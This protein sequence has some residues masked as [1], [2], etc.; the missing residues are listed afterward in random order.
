MD[1]EA[2]LT[3][4]IRKFVA[5]YLEVHGLAPNLG[6][7]GRRF[8]SRTRKWTGLSVDEL[9]RKDPGFTL[10]VQLSGKTLVV[11]DFDIER[12]EEK[13]REREALAVSASVSKD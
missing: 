8:G 12:A 1:M 5:D 10:E 9:L 4:E 13:M 3:E 7:L 6:M 2:K 11:C